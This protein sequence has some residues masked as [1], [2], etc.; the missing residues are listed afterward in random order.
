MKSLCLIDKRRSVS[1]IRT[2]GVAGV[3]F[4]GSRYSAGPACPSTSSSFRRGAAT[5]PSRRIGL[6]LVRPREDVVSSSSRQPCITIFASPVGACSRPATSLSSSS[7]ASA[8]FRSAAS[9][10]LSSS[11]T[12]ARFRP[13]ASSS[14]SSSSASARFRPAASSSSSSCWG[15]PPL[16]CNFHCLFFLYVSP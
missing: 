16:V 9:S 12:S 3:P 2:P 10:S 14:L 13:A 6:E 5:S 15:Q 11:S 4:E 7:S 8:C 1:S